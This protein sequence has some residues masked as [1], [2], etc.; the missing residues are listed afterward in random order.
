MGIA[1]IL[2]T[3]LG[4]LNFEQIFVP[5]PIPVKLHMQIGFDWPREEN[6]CRMQTMDGRTTEAC[7]Y[8]KLTHEPLWA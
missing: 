4:P 7:L 2:V 3:S 6:V 8:Y 5:S 1:A